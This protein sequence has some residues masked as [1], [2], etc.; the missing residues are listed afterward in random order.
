[1]K[2]APGVE[3]VRMLPDGTVVGHACCYVIWWP[4]DDV[5]RAAG[6]KDPAQLVR[7]LRLNRGNLPRRIDL[8]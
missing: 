1:M 5:W 4:G 6:F 8:L 3:P 2:T 7:W